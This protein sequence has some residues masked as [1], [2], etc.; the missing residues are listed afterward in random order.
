MAKSI[1]PD[2]RLDPLT[3]LPG[4]AQFLATASDGLAQQRAAWAALLIIDIDDLTRINARSGRECGDMVIRSA[5]HQLKALVRAKDSVC[6]FDGGQF[7]A[8]LVGTDPV[9]ARSIAD[10]LRMAVQD[11][12]LCADDG[13]AI[14][15]TV[16]IGIDVVRASALAAPGNLELAL[17][18]AAV[19]LRDAK[20]A[21]GNRV[22]APRRSHPPGGG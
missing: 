17:Q 15:A 20:E 1:D 9:R 2:R 5:A 12:E 3:G 19:R 13:T 7:V 22:V 16:S 4:R 6:R 11:L 18:V 21:G 10:R 8:L 14:P